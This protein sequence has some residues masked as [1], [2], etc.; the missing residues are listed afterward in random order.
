MGKVRYFKIV[1]DERYFDIHER[2]K[3]NLQVVDCLDYK[4]IKKCP[5]GGSS[6]GQSWVDVA[7]LEESNR[8]GLNLIRRKKNSCD[9]S[10]K[11]N[12]TT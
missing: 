4:E 2:A 7:C 9:T 10:D 8:A 3:H 5:C 1:T 6:Q 11:K 12:S